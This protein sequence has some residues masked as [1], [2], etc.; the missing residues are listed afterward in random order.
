MKPIRF[1]NPHRQKHFDYFNQMNHPH[2]NICGNI[3]ISEFLKKSKD[4][5]W[6]FTPA[7]VYF[8]SK[9]A[10][11]IPEFRQ[12][13]RDNEVVEHEVVHPSFS[14]YTK[15]SDV[16]SFCETKFQPD[17]QGFMADAKINIATMQEKPVFEDEP[18]RDDYLFLSAIPW[19]RFTGI[20][21]AMHYHPAD[22][23]PRISWGKYFEEGG[24][25][26]MPIAVQVHHALVD[27]RHVGEFFIGLEKLLS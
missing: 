4:L 20:S 27:G 25:M 18:G 19:I 23:V 1:T 15:A 3:D 21:H 14:V 11:A 5:G 16:F 22:S 9:S 8:I 12:R 6:S 17:F 7:I 10:N 26:R 24:K 2:F 13:I